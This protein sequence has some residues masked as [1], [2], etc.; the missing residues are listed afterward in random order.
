MTYYT[1][2]IDHWSA[3][4]RPQVKSTSLKSTSLPHVMRFAAQLS[5]A[6]PDAEITVSR[7]THG[8]EPQCASRLVKERFWDYVE[9]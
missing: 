4:N 5:V 1:A 3:A 2:T 9:C 8:L 7:H 6:S